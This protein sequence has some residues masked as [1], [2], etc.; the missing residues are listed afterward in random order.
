MYNRNLELTKGGLE[1]GTTKKRFSKEFK[2]KIA[3]EAIKGTKT[4]AEISSEFGVHS[5]QIAKWKNK[6]RDSLPD[7]FAGKRDPQEKQN[8]A[9]VRELYQQIGEL[10]VE[11][12]WLKKKLPF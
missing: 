8:Q 6:L 12:G 2:A 11:N 10:Q 7:I 3:I 5:S 9:L 4:T 1:M